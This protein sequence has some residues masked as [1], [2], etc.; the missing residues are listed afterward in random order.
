LALRCLN[1]PMMQAILASLQGYAV[2]MD[3]HRQVIG[4]NRTL[5]QGLDLPDMQPIHGLRPGEIFGCTHLPESVCGC[6]TAPACSQCGAL[7]TILSSQTEGTSV[8]GECWMTLRQEGAL[9]AKEFACRATPIG[10]EGIPCTVFVLQDI[11]AEKR[12]EVLE[13]LF[14]HD[15]SNSFQALHNWMELFALD[16]K[17]ASSKAMGL[18]DRIQQE[19][20]QHRLLLEAERGE[21]KVKKQPLE[22]R[23]ILEELSS[24]FGNHPLV[25]GKRLIFQSPGEKTP[26]R[27]DPTL[28]LRILING[29]VNALE[30][31]PQGGEV[32]TWFHWVEDCPAFTI[33]N[34]EVIPPEVQSRIFQRSFSTKA[35]KGRGL[36]TYSMKLLGEDF[37]G[38]SLTMRSKLT[39]GTLFT[40]VLPCG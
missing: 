13:S 35:S 28:L 11:S 39:E 25:A 37:L 15:L 10:L 26:F 30:A 12:K 21:L 31:T 8:A 27:S 4:V 9:Q 36:G 29:I 38:G 33:H 2:V 40:L 19:I 17:K 22:A 32:R 18:V 16:P 34:A 1:N 14:L 24:F 7:L 23:S 3:R 5:L 20:S 6:G